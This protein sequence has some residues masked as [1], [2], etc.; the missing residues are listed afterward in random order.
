M[1]IWNS[2]I[3]L[4]QNLHDEIINK[5]Q[6]NHINKEDFYT[7]FYKEYDKFMFLIPYYGEVIERIMKD[8]GMFE[9]SIYRYDLWVQMYNSETTTHEPH[10]HFTDH[11]MY[12]LMSFNH[13]IDASKEKC[14]YF[15]DDDNNK[16]YPDN[17]QS[18]DIF[19][20]CPWLTH[21]VDKVKEP[22]TNRLIVAGNI[23][24]ES[25]EDCVIRCET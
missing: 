7:S 9:K 5:I 19:T 10:Q 13:I 23:M 4:P 1:L 3:K 18:G 22:N 25:Y 14:F 21:G 20:W 24:L 12:P 17:Q 2:N 16:I 8:L 15:L 11:N 6:K